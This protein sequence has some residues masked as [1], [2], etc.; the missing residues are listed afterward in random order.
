M[1]IPAYI[2]QLYKPIQ[3]TVNQSA[4]HVSYTEALPHLKLQ[5]VVY[6]YW[7]LKTT[8]NLAEPFIYR[9][10]ADGCIDIFFELSNPQDN[11]VMGFCKKF[12]EFPLENSFNYIGVRFLPTM[13]PQLFNVDASELSNRFDQLKKVIPKTSDFI[14]SQINPSLTFDEVKRILDAYF[15]EIL[16]N[17][18][19]DHDARLYGAIEIILQKSGVVDIESDLNTGISSRQLR[20][21][22]EFY[23][24]DSAKTFS[25]IVRFQNIL[26]AKPSSQSLRQNKLF[27]N[28]G[29]YDQAHFIKEFRNFYGVTPGKAF[30]R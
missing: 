30:G 2:R 15:L 9:V 19:F 16:E 17:S 18:S 8:R 21:L 3:P 4:E 23:I 1:E 7:Q 10:V 12:T 26:K 28:V 14:T 29:Y 11:F 20:R 24:G 5:S 22:F 6:C 27:F 13:F 25:K